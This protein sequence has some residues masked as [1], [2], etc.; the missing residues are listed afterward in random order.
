MHLVQ[1][2]G[3]LGFCYQV[4]IV[5]VDEIDKVCSDGAGR[6]SS[7][8]QSTLQ[9]IGTCWYECTGNT[10]LVSDS[11]LLDDVSR[12]ATQSTFLKLMEERWGL[13]MVL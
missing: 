9:L 11:L 8:R 4:G 1:L 2:T 10:W 6:N 3:T 5:Y 12:R 13:T 7:F